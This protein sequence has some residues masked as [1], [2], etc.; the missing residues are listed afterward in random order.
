MNY[1][2]LEQAAT[3]IG[4]G[5]TAEELLRLGAGLEIK[6]CAGFSGSYYS[7][8]QEKNTEMSGLYVI[9][10]KIL[11]EIE[12]KKI[13]SCGCAFSLDG[14]EIFF[15]YV[16]L[17]INS[18]RITADELDKFK[19]RIVDSKKIQLEDYVIEILANNYKT[20][21]DE[22]DWNH[23]FNLPYWTAQEA[24]YLLHLYEP[25]KVEEHKILKEKYSKNSGWGESIKKLDKDLILAEREQ[26]IGILNIRTTPLA[27]VDWAVKK[28]IRVPSQFNKFIEEKSFTNH[29]IKYDD[30]QFGLTEKNNEYA[31]NTKP[32]LIANKND[33]IPVYD[34]FT[35]ARFFAREL[36][37]QNPLLI[38]NKDILALKV[39]ELFKKYEIKKRGGKK[40]FDPST[41]KKAFSNVN[42]S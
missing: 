40:D 26:Q 6:I 12:T 2:T 4:Y 7:P 18:L 32:W 37:N 19:S 33:P 29:K 17:D 30:E 24:I 36:L 14:K 1:F 25:S 23:W 13:S 9:P 16:D 35:P 41:I 42:F 15:P 39:N 34:W 28:G 20:A 27:W 8:T 3:H 21:S 22:F 31:S 10:P 11:F 38:N 5:V